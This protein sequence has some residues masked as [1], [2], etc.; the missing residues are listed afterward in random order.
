[1]GK[2]Q[3]TRVEFSNNASVYLAELAFTLLVNNVFS[4][5]EN[6]EKYVDFISDE[7]NKNIHFKKH[8]PTSSELT[9]FGKYYVIINT[10]KRTAWHV[11]FDKKDNRYFINKIT[12]NHL[13]SAKTLNTI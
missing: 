8:H 6:A 2:P 7:I 9:K 12:N 13:P 5:I 4:Y 11:F 3:Q 10:N 1:M